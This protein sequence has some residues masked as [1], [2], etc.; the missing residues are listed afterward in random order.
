MRN[1]SG[2]LGLRGHFNVTEHVSAW[3]DPPSRRRDLT[4]GGWCCLP[5]RSSLLVVQP[6]ARFLVGGKRLAI[7]QHAVEDHS[8][9]SGMRN[10]S[11]ILAGACCQAHGTVLENSCFSGLDRIMCAA[12]YCAMGRPRRPILEIRP[13]TSFSPGWSRFGVRPK[14]AQTCRERWQPLP[15]ARSDPYRRQCTGSTV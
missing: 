1:R 2:D 10:L 4:P 7:D 11:L 5:K 8:K 3:R 15:P 14:R 12:S 13:L 6:L 9:L